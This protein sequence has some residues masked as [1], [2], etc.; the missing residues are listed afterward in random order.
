MPYTN[1]FI[2]CCSFIRRCVSAVALMI[3]AAWR[4]QYLVKVN[5][6]KTKKGVD[7]LQHLVDFHHAQDK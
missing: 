7:L 6:I 4:F 3:P 5:E 2:R 1:S